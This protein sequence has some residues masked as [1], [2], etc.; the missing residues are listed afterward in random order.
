MKLPIK[1]LFLSLY[2]LTISNTACKK[3]EVVVPEITHTVTI[4][5]S[6]LNI[7][8]QPFI[9][10]ILK[11]N[12]DQAEVN[13]KEI[14]WSSSDSRIATVND[15]G[16]VTA[17][18]AG[19]AEI[20]GRLINGKGAAKCKVT[21]SD[22]NAYKFRIILK[23]KGTSE[24]SVNAPE[25]YLSAK[26]IQRRRK[27]NITINET[28]LPIS[29]EYIQ[30]IKKVGGV[31]VT[32]SKWLNTVTVYT[33]DQ[34]SLYKYK[35]L[36][37]VKDVLITWRGPKVSQVEAY[38]SD[39]AS[40]STGVPPD[41]STK[42]AAYYGSAWKNISINN[43]QQIHEK[44]YTGTG[45]D[46]AVIDAGFKGLNTNP[47]FQNMHIKAAKSFVFE[48]HNPYDIDEHGVWVTSCMATN[49]PGYYVG[50]APNANYWLLRS[51]DESTEYT[52]EEDYWVA[53]I[54]Y[55]DSAGVD[56][57]NTSLYYTSHDG[58]TDNY[59]FENMDGKTAMASRAANIASDKG[60]FVVACAGN[61]Q[62]WVGTPGDSPNVL[63]VGSVNS[64]ETIDVFT[65]YGITTDGRIKPDV[66]SLGGGASV[67]T[68][69]GTFMNRSG[70][71]YA[72]PIICGL[73]ACLL[74]AYPKLNN[75]ELL[76]II[77]KSGNRFAH[78]ELP[79]GYGICDISKAM[80]L[81]QALTINR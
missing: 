49:K 4:A 7:E 61:D 53:A 10:Y 11:V 22:A 56:I 32:Q 74:Q 14:I 78:P 76:G 15:Q 26:A 48:N 33:T 62:R 25:R 55:A 9:S 60:I 65:S 72:S 59:K 17:M 58:E 30:E 27:Q 70:T 54:E 19:E 23:D 57:V 50:T 39:G 68:T 18:A 5:P 44:G 3:A 12:F 38:N 24:F 40:S 77:R 46:I 20:T 69:N 36:P 73:A 41:H 35:E 34:L 1:L 31:I 51:E 8:K 52:V 47:S 43:G 37:F 63:T 79:Y 42:D 6:A 67:I 2:L 45:I 64:I 81:A 75:H 28:D 71:S 29:K 16:F 21:I 13:N 66:V 80:Q